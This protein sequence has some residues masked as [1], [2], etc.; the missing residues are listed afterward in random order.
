MYNID[1]IYAIYI[2]YFNILVLNLKYNILNLKYNILN[3][4]YNI[5]NV[6]RKDLDYLRG[7]VHNFKLQQG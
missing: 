5:C 1:E 6:E 7:I 2:K 3:L 4:K